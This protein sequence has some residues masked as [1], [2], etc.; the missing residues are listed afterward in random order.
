RARRRGQDGRA[1]RRRHLR[2]ADPRRGFQS[3]VRR[4]RGA[5]GGHGAQPRRVVWRRTLS[6][7]KAF[8]ALLKYKWTARSSRRPPGVRSSGLHASR[9]RAVVRAGVSARTAQPAHLSRGCVLRRP[10]PHGAL[11]P[12][13]EVIGATI[14]LPPFITNTTRAVAV[15]SRSGSPSSA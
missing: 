15:M 5:D 6:K 14:T 10:H 7:E 3:Q 11:F 4:S 2:R 1:A 13:D 9:S 12:A 8:V